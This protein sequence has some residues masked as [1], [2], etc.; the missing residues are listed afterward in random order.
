MHR[1]L[2]GMEAD[3][4][5]GP[6]LALPNPASTAAMRRAGKLPR[7]LAQHLLDRPDSGRQTEAFE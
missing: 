2:A 7:V 6:A 4:A 1:N 5:P 3:L